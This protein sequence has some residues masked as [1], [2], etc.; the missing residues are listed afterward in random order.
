VPDETPVDNMNTLWA[1]P[2]AVIDLKTEYR[3]NDHVSLFG[4]ITNRFDEKYPFDP[5]R[6]TGH[7]RPGRLPARRR[8]R[9][10]CRRQKPILSHSSLLHDKDDLRDMTHAGIAVARVRVLNRPIGSPVKLRPAPRRNEHV[11]DH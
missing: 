3:I 8:P 4:E 5:D 7:R 2:Y 9:L 6:R 11:L 10:L 1:D